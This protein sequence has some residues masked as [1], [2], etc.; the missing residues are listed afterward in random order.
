[1]FGFAYGGLTEGGQGSSHSAY[2]QKV[3][4]SIFCSLS[5]VISYHLSRCSSDPSVVLSLMKRHAIAI[6]CEDAVGVNASSSNS[7]AQSPLEE[8]V[9][10]QDPLPKK[11]RDTVNARLKNDAIICSVA[12]IAVFLLHQSDVL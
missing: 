6:L 3:L 9:I 10:P 5:V 2:A 7:G 8:Q 12:A 1:M 11:L 4:F